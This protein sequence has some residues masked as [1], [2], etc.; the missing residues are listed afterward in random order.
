MDKTH[1]LAP[2]L[3]DN[4]KM[5][6]RYIRLVAKLSSLSE[7]ELKCVATLLELPEIS[8]EECILEVI[9]NA[10]E[11]GGDEVMETVENYIRGPPELEE[12]N[13]KMEELELLKSQYEELAKKMESLTKGK[14]GDFD[15]IEPV[16]RFL[17]PI[18]DYKIQGN[19]GSPG[20]K[21]KLSYVSLIRQMELGI[22]KKIS[23]KEIVHQ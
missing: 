19:I 10:M 4:L 21:G 14:P 7:A 20:E 5:N 18:R 8:E 11:K 9:S 22:E 23:E 15:F 1:I 12:T 16:S 2:V 13:S 6:L 3:T 17:S